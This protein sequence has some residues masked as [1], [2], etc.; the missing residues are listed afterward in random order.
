MVIFLLTM[1]IK[2]V[3][4][5]FIVVKSLDPFVFLSGFQV[6]ILSTKCWLLGETELSFAACVAGW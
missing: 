6:L 5:F 3:I 1:E 2:R 4:T